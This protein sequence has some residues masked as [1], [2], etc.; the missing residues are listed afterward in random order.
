M[1]TTNPQAD[2]TF[3]SDLT[4][5]EFIVLNDAGWE[6]LAFV[7]GD[8]TSDPGDGHWSV[9]GNQGDAL[10]RAQSSAMERL[11]QQAAEA[12][13]VGVVGVRLKTTEIMYEKELPSL[14]HFSAIGTAIRPAG[15]VSTK[16]TV[17]FTSHLS[18]QDIWALLAAGC[19]P[20]GMVFGVGFYRPKQL[21]RK[22]QRGFQEVSFLTEGVYA[23]RES[24]MQHMQSQAS[25]LHASGVVGV[26]V[27]MALAHRHNITFTAIGT[28]ISTPARGLA[29]L[30]PKLAIDLKDGDLRSASAG[31]L[32]LHGQIAI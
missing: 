19:K 8:C 2:T 13:A 18:G 1:T 23:A 4:V 24:A 28:A 26:T 16:S 30:T 20:L 14:Y 6:P 12:G 7:S 17:P 3:T 15:K 25:A 31:H 21:F 11:R 5:D 29:E 22:P 9:G 32:P 10:T 27:E